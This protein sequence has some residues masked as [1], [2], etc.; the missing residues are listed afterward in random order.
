MQFS[1]AQFGAIEDANEKRV[2]SESL[3]KF[4]NEVRPI[5]PR[6]AEDIANYNHAGNTEVFKRIIALTNIGDYER[7]LLAMFLQTG[8]DF[9]TDASF[10]YIIK[11]PAL[12][13]NTKARHIILMAVAMKKS[14][15]DTI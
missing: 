1:N 14:M 15:D 2:L 4:E 6:L 12:S 11:N 5:D 10:S 13:G 8:I 9:T 3:I 7:A